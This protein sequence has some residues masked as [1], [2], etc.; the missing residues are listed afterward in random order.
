M[1]DELDPTLKV[2]DQVDPQF[3]NNEVVHN[4]DLLLPEPLLR[5]WRQI[6]GIEQND[7]IR[8]PANREP[9]GRDLRR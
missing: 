5:G 1:L 2:D 7:A 4:P 3:G 9:I 8:P 6:D